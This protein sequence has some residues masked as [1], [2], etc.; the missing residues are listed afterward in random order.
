MSCSY[1]VIH[2]YLAIHS[3]LFIQDFL[4]FAYASVRKNERSKKTCEACRKLQLFCGLSR[5]V[6]L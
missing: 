4:L 6:N 2:S 5:D 3:F 1:F